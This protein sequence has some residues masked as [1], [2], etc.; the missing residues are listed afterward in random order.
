VASH[1]V[2]AV[3]DETS[4][5]SRIP[6][7]LI[8]L[9]G[10]SHRLLPLRLGAQVPAGVKKYCELTVCSSA[11]YGIPETIIFFLVDPALDYE[12]L[13]DGF[14]IYFGRNSF[15]TQLK[16]EARGTGHGVSSGGTVNIGAYELEP[17]GKPTV[18]SGRQMFQS[19]LLSSGT[20][21]S[22]EA[23]STSL[24]TRDTE[25]ASQG[26]YFDPLDHVRDQLIYP[27]VEE[28]SEGNQISGSLLVSL[29][30][31]ISPTAPPMSSKAIDTELALLSGLPKDYIPPDVS[32]LSSPRWCK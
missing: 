31:N 29:V 19:R 18:F 9:L 1:A 22:R 10:L 7:K 11:V 20:N 15:L 30:T 14:P 26:G 6:K 27:S 8:D 25:F 28:F 32:P 2:P 24:E 23:P 16:S 3:V 17:V 21:L 4:E 13:G 12:R 5:R